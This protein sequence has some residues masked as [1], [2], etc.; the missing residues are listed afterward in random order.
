MKDAEAFEFPTNGRI[1]AWK[2]LLL[3][4]LNFYCWDTI[5][6]AC[7]GVFLGVSGACR[8]DEDMEPREVDN[9]RFEG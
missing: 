8:E 3:E 5:Q 1:V 4:R 9:E 2:G 6:V 7:S